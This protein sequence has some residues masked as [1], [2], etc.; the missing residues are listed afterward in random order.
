[1]TTEQVLLTL[2]EVS[3][4]FIGFSAVMWMLGISGFMLTTIVTRR[5][6]A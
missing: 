1:V 3:V 6:G 5:G 4:A 2:A